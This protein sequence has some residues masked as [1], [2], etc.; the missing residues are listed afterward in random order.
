MFKREPTV[1]LGFY[2]EQ[3]EIWNL[4]R[5][6]LLNRIQHPAV[7]QPTKRQEPTRAPEVDEDEVRHAA[8]LALVGTVDDSP[9]A[10]PEVTHG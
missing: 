2:E 8:E 5:A 6:S 7:F 4:E 10:E 9:P 1:P 3:L